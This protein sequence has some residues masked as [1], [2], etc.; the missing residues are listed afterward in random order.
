MFR[1]FSNFYQDGVFLVLP[2]SRQLDICPQLCNVQYFF[3]IVIVRNINVD[4]FIFNPFI[5]NIHKKSNI[6][7]LYASPRLKA[8]FKSTSRYSFYN[9][10]KI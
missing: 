8:D 3:I 2:I 10:L 1:I 4:K 6:I 7:S 5:F 9:V